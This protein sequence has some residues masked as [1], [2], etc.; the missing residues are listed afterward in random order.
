MLPLKKSRWH[1]VT[2]WLCSQVQAKQGFSGDKNMQSEFTIL[3][4]PVWK[5]S[6][7]EK[8]Q[9][10]QS[11]A[12]VV[13]WQ[14]HK[15]TDQVITNWAGL[16]IQSQVLDSDCRDA[17]PVTSSQ[18]ATSREGAR[19]EIWSENKFCVRLVVYQI[20][21][22]WIERV[23]SVI[24]KISCSKLVAFC[25]S[26]VG[27]ALLTMIAIKLII[28]NQQ[29]DLSILPAMTFIKDGNKNSG[30]LSRG[31]VLTEATGWC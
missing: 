30:S 7:E 8:Y 11:F 31:T 6:S 18:H 12:S 16:L 21:T 9:I 5:I 25:W 15:A 10:C 3:R 29:L 20:R 1:C 14:H 22:S 23:A 2:I 4:Q 28:R 19:L 24:R 17:H 26:D 13:L 27:S